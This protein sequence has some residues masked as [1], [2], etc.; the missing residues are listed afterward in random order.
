MHD[1]PSEM[2]WTFISTSTSEAMWIYLTVAFPNSEKC[3]AFVKS[4]LIVLWGDWRQ[5]YLPMEMKQMDNTIYA[6]LWK[7]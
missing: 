1:S 7:C 3:V 4:K 2:K 5:T 6:L